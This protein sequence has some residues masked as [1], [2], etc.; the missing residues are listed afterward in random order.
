MTPNPVVSVVVAV[1]NCGRYLRRCLESLLSQTF[2]DFEVLLIDDGSSDGSGGI[3]DEYAGK[4]NRFKVV[5]Q[6]NRG[7]S[8]ARHAGEERACGEYIIFADADDWMEP[9]MVGMMVECGADSNADVVGCNFFVDREKESEAYRIRFQGKDS[10]LHDVV[11]NKWGVLW[12]HLIRRSLLQRHGIAFNP[13]FGASED[14]H[15]MVRCLYYA[16]KIAYVEECLYHYNCSNSN[17]ISTARK[18]STAQWYGRATDCVEEFLEGRGILPAYENDLVLRKINVKNMFLR[19][20]IPLW[21]SNYPEVAGFI[22]KKD[23]EI[24]LKRRIVYTALVAI[25]IPRKI[26]KILRNRV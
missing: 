24:P 9:D 21:N 13:D 6:D 10:Y 14:Y 22:W 20:G 17:S 7:V 5:H 12:R 11:A 18:E 26:I 8:A 4:D 3:C 15:Y 2:G 23:V 1:Y 16:E 25:D 19:F